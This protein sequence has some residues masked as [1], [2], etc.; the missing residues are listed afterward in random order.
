MKIF[1]ISSI[2]PL[3]ELK[4]END[5]VLRVQDN[6]VSTYSFKFVIAKSLPLS[7]VFISKISAK[8]IKYREYKMKGEINVLGYKTHIYDWIML[9][10]SNFWINYLL[11]SVNYLRFNLIIRKQLEAE[12]INS[13]LIVSQNLIPDAL[14]SYWLSRCYNKP[15]IINLR[16]ASN[17]DWFRLPLMKKMINSADAIITHSPTNYYK[18][19]PSFNLKLI[20]HPVDEIFFN[21]KNERGN[22]IQLLSVCRLLELKNINKVLFSI[23]D[24]KKNGYR[25]K[26]TIVGDGPEYINLNKLVTKLELESEVTF[27]GHLDMASVAKEMKKAHIFVMPSYPETLGRVY[28]EA[29]AAGCLIIGHEKTGVDGFLKNYESAYFVNLN[30]LTSYLR[31]AIDII[32]S[33][34]YDQIVRASNYKVQKLTW[35]DIGSVY[36]ELYRS[37]IIK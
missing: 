4:R 21:D 37:L 26:Y 33:S 24:L 27:A 32:G 11:I 25:F 13:D 9:P 23:V 18:F 12:V 5:I 7:P 6:L 34:D 31:K 19:K 28:L 10:T 14:V 8:W 2:I 3:P 22:D 30:N 16:G 1:N 15:F 36:N 20:P 35:T 17:R 29:A